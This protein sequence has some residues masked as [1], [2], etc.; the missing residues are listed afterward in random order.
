MHMHRSLVGGQAALNKEKT[1]EKGLETARRDRPCGSGG[2]WF[3]A[4]AN[5]SKV[6][7]TVSRYFNDPEQE[8]LIPLQRPRECR[9][10]ASGEH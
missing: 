3:G 7:G 10:S 6:S 9:I 4:R 5:A 8:S 2:F 1:S